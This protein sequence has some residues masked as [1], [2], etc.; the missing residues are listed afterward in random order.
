[1]HELAEYVDLKAASERLRTTPK[2]YLS[3]VGRNCSLFDSLRGWAYRWV[4]DYKT[5]G[6]DSWMKR[7]EQ[8]AEK[9]NTFVH[10]LPF[11]E[12]RS[13]SKSVGKWT[14]QRY[15]GSYGSKL[16]TIALAEQGLTPDTFS[17]LQSSL[18]RMGNEKRWGNND[19]KKAE[20]LRLK[21]EGMN[22][23]A[24]AQTLEVNQATVSRWLK[25]NK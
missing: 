3:G 15:T 19:D 18:G 10:P 6:R 21:S 2:K 11:G 22:Q 1:M 14:W 20:A 7:V 4:D 9:L 8:Q 25:L 5:L 24:I 12:V 23:A 17:L 13:I 16:D